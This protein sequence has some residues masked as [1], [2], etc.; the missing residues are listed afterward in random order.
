MFLDFFEN[1]W[2]YFTALGMPNQV[3]VV[4]EDDEVFKVLSA[5]KYENKIRLERSK[6][7]SH[8][9]SED[10][11]T[12]EY[13]KMVSSIFDKTVVQQKSFHLLTLLKILDKS[14]QLKQLTKSTS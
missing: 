6:I 7:I 4:A 12:K 8:A 1:W 10:Y 14:F 11:G 5:Q 3:V 9:A 2:I 13:K